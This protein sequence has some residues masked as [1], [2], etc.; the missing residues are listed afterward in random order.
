[1]ASVTDV[2]PSLFRTVRTV[3][4][5]ASDPITDVSCNDAER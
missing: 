3:S 4:S 2:E 5:V 1:M